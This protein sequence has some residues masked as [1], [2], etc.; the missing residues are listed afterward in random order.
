MTFIFALA[1]KSDEG[2]PVSIQSDNGHDWRNAL[3]GGCI[4]EGMSKSK[5]FLS[6]LNINQTITAG[7]YPSFLIT[8]DTHPSYKT[9]L[10]EV[11][12]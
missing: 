2:F 9:T 1:F 5:A 6:S 12:F 10:T 3:E 4:L 11:E 8:L 7:K